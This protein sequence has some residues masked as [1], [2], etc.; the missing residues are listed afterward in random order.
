MIKSKNFEVDYEDFVPVNPNSKTANQLTK[1]GVGTHVVKYIIVENGKPYKKVNPAVLS[2]N[3]AKSMAENPN[4]IF[5]QF[6][7]RVIKDLRK[8][9]DE[10]LKLPF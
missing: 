3:Y 7:D 2:F 9:D 4:T 10:Q 1:D 6:D 5:V 8:K